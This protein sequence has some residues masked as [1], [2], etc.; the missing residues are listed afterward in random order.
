MRYVLAH[1]IWVGSA[2]LLW[3]FAEAQWYAELCAFATGISVGCFASVCFWYRE[4]RRP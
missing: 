4:Q 3:L 1:A 2:A